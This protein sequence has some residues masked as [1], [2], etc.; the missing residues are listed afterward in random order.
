MPSSAYYTEDNQYLL[1][2]KNEHTTHCSGQ[3]ILL[4]S[5]LRSVLPELIYSNPTRQTLEKVVEW[6]GD[7]PILWIWNAKVQIPGLSFISRVTMDKL[8]NIYEPSVKDDT[9]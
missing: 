5:S 7:E 8:L 4:K 2:E 1:K 6:N 3:Q 9:S